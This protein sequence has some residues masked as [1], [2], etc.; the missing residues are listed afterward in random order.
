MTRRTWLTT[1]SLAGATTALLGLGIA[2]PAQAHA[3]VRCETLRAT[4]SN[5]QGLSGGTV[6]ATVCK[7]GDGY[8]YFH[9][10]YNNYVED[11]QAD[12]AAARAYVRDSHG[13][14]GPLAVDDTSTSDGQ[15]I[16]W[17]SNGSGNTTIRV[18]V[19][20]GKKYPGDSGARCA[21]DSMS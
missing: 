19:C 2:L 8:A 6:Q 5:S 17:E 12:G 18:Y 16:W 13:L 1:A 9:D 10:S 14:Y 21:S 11:Y 7:A 3:A 15:P 20:L 4:V